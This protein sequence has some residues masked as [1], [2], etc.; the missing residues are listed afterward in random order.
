MSPP[1]WIFPN[2]ES[3]ENH[4]AY[5][6]SWLDG[7]KGDSSFIFKASSMAAKSTDYLL[8][9]VRKADAVES[10]NELIAA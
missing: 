3:L 10:E 7:M 5:L 1:N 2:G 8:S 4:A 9:F 6:K